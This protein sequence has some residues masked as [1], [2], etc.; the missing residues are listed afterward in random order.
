MVLV[1]K[2]RIQMFS[3]EKLSV[4]SREFAGPYL[5]LGKYVSKQNI[6]VMLFSLEPI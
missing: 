4:P 2:I 3:S 5:A 6:T 1:A